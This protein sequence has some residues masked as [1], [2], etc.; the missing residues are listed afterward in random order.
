MSK[1]KQQS[2]VN[3]A[4]VLT[5]AMLAVKVIGILFKMPLTNTIGMIG[6]GY[7]DLVYQIYT[8]IFA[9]SVA[10]LPIAVARMIS[11]SVALK[12][13]RDTRAILQASRKIFLIAGIVGTA[14]LMIIAKPYILITNAPNEIMPGIIAVAPAI[15]FCC[16]MSSYRGYYEGLR[17]M[18]PTAASQF[19]EALGKLIVGLLLAKMVLN[20]GMVGVYDKTKT[21]DG[22]A[23]VFGTVVHNETEAYAAIIP[24]AAVGA[25][26][27]V[28]IG[29]ILGLFYLMARHKLNG[30]GLTRLDLEL[31]PE[32]KD[33]R[34]IS[35]E[36]LKIALPVVAGALILNVSNLIDT[37]TIVG[38]TSVALGKDFGTVW[39]MHSGALDSALANENLILGSDAQANNK[40]IATYLFGAYN[41]GVDFRNLV[42]TITSGFGISVLPVLAAAW[43]TRNREEVRRSI[44]SI[45]RLCLLIAL[46]AG[47]GIAILAKPLLTIIYGVGN[48]SDGITVAVPVL[49]V[50]GV[51]TALLAL[52]TP[53]TNMLQGLGRTDIPV[54]TMAFCTVVKIICN[55]VLIGIPALNIYGSMIGTIIF[56]IFDVGVNLYFLKKITQVRINWKSVFVKPLACAILCGGAAWAGY[57]LSRRGIEKILPSLTD[58]SF[59]QSG[60]GAKLGDYLLNANTLAALISVLISII[61]Y[62]VALLLTKS[63]TRDDVI[64]LPK[65]EK[66]AKALAKR[67]LL[68]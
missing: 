34:A 26:L 4:I 14:I 18:N 35:K 30:D 36:L 22:T 16:M 48:A 57:G 20:Y 5:F 33:R 54:K 53:I 56:Y 21:A 55:I 44:D 61:I 28:T 39:A 13:Y 6:R 41:T 25:V 15:F 62:V 43:A 52:S 49:Q 19:I 2:L 68:G 3:G 10:G 7:F 45:M 59:F 66:I 8:P 29:S 1:K 37:M 46:P 42:P 63:V 65:G 31:S 11:E 27:G 9:I 67:G 50:Y 12:R 40:L 24:W 47:F 58:M 64:G 51:V 23:E 38:R 17:N 60:F 32:A